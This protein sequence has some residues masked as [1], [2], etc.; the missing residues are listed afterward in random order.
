[1]F[2][3]NF[4][5]CLDSE[6]KATDEVPEKPGNYLFFEQVVKSLFSVERPIVNSVQFHIAFEIKTLPPKR[7]MLNFFFLFVFFFLSQIF[8]RNFQI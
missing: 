7:L 5:L 8:P 3:L 6:K 1:M 4:H 2:Q